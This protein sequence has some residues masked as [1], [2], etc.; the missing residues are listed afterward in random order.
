MQPLFK[1]RIVKWYNEAA[2]HQQL[3]NTIKLQS[4]GGSDFYV[5]FGCKHYSK[6]SPAHTCDSKEHTLEVVKGMLE[7]KTEEQPFKEMECQTDPVVINVSEENALLQKKLDK[8]LKEKKEAEDVAYEAGEFE[9]A[10]QTMIELL[11]EK[12]DTAMLDIMKSSY[13][14]IYGKIF[15][16]LGRPEY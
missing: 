2:N 3:Y 12:D 14:E 7:T 4:K 15:K 9:D 6:T 1:K 13:P 10:L 5:C 16:N 11:I 8:A